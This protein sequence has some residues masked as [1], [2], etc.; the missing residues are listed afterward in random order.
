MKTLIRIVSLSLIVLLSSAFLTHHEANA[1]NSIENELNSRPYSI[2]A[3]YVM[4]IPITGYFPPRIWLT[5][6][7][8]RG[9]VY[10]ESY[11]LSKRNTY[12]GTYRGTLYLHIA[13]LNIIQ[14]EM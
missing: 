14:E 9:Y 3:T 2:E 11:Y 4:Q 12:V 8:Y 7:D 1:Q 6:G 5:R 10:K 13:P